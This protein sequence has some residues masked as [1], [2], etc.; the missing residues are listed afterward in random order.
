MRNL[1]ITHNAPSRRQASK[2]AFTV[3]LLQMRRWE[4]PKPSKDADTNYTCPMHPE[5]VQNGPGD[6]PKCGMALEPMNPPATTKIEYTCPMH[7][8]IVRNEPGSCPIC[9]MALRSHR[10]V[11]ATEEKNPELRD[12]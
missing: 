7:P 9:G 2:A 10:E 6:C 5:V 12:M 1:S 3:T 8:E 11:T 4:S